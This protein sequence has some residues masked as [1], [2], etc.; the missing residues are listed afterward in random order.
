LPNHNPIKLVKTLFSLESALPSVDVDRL[1]KSSGNKYALLFSKKN[2]SELAEIR[3]FVFFQDGG[4]RH[5]EFPESAIF[6]A[7]DT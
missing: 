2:F 6:D 7:D 5:L 4:R 3:S 1:K